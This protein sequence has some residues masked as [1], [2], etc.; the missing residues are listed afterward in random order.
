MTKTTISFLIDDKKRKALDH[1]AKSLDRDRSYILNE[2]IAS[3]LDFNQWQSER[4]QKGLQQSQK[5]QYVSEEKIDKFF[6][7]WTHAKD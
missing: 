4:I 7:K 3:Y 6:K 5:K 1:I 2:A